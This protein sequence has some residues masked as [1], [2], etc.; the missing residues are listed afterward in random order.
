MRILQFLY[1]IVAMSDLRDAFNLTNYVK[2]PSKMYLAFLY[3]N[4]IRNVL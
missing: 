1:G 3:C 4:A 2:M